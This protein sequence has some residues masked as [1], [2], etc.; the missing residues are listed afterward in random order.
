MYQ[1]F[2]VSKGNKTAEKIGF[3]YAEALKYDAG[4]AVSVISCE[5]DYEIDTKGFYQPVYRFEISLP[6]TDYI[7]PAMIPA[8]K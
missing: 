3:E 8:I 4:D 2:I 7:C 6:G 5:L 1:G